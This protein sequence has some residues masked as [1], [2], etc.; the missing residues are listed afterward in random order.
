MKENILRRFDEDTKLAKT[1]S[2]LANGLKIGIL[3]NNDD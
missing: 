3:T 2:R 1:L